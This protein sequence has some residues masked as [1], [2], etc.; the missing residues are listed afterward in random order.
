MKTDVIQILKALADENR[1]KLVKSLTCG[2]EKTCGA[3]SAPLNKI[4]QPTIS[5]HIK[6]LSDAEII[7]V[8]KEG[9][10]CNYIL[11]NKKL[12]DIGIDIKKLLN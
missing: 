12:E 6:V 4:S 2:T 8:R 3:I 1:L 7:H 10:S 5:H 9:T 11:N